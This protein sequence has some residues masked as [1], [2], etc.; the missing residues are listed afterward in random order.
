MAQIK[1]G[2]F[3]IVDNWDGPVLLT[4]TAEDFCKR[5]ADEFDEQELLYIDDEDNEDENKNPWTSVKPDA[6][7][8]FDANVVSDWLVAAFDM[9]IG[10]DEAKPKHRMLWQYVAGDGEVVQQHST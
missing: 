9:G 2:V 1:D 6:D 4:M 7:A 3:R 8:E 5:L 10:E